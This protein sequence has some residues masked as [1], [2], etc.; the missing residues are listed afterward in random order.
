MIESNLMDAKVFL[1][2]QAISLDAK[3]LRL[4]NRAMGKLIQ[5]A[6]E[7]IVGKRGYWVG[8]RGG[9][10]WAKAEPGEPPKNRTGFLRRSI[11]GFPTQVGFAMYE[12]VVGPTAVSS[13]RLEV[14]GGKW[15]AGLRF[16]YMQPAFDKFAALHDGIV[17]E[18]YGGE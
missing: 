14:G 16:P 4:R 3:A 15:P 6:K 9:I 2:K 12:A 17:Q 7:E 13:R 10:M 1:T 5:L 11:T 18:I 8:P